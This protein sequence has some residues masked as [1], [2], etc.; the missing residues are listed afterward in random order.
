LI[1]FKL[2][3]LSLSWKQS[4]RYKRQHNLK[5]VQTTIKWHPRI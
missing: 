2:D 3:L 4:V 5:A 1:A